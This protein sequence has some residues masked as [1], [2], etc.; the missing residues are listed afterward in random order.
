MARLDDKR[1][2]LKNT[3]RGSDAEISRAMSAVRIFVV[4]ATVAFVGGGFLFVHHHFKQSNP[5]LRSYGDLILVGPPPWL[6]EELKEKIGYAA[7]ADGEDLRLD[8]DAAVTIQNHLRKHLVWLAD[9]KVR[10]NPD[11]IEISGRWRK[12][13]AQIEVNNT[14]FYLDAES[15]VLDYVEVPELPI[16]QIAGVRL[17]GLPTIGEALASPDI[18]AAM[19]ILHRM[20][21][22]DRL[23]TPDAPLLL[24]IKSINIANFRGRLSKSDPHITMKSVGGTDIV[25]GAELDAWSEQLEASDEEKLAKLYAYYRQSRCLDDGV[26]FINLREPRDRIPRPVE[27]LPR[28]ANPLP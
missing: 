28:A 21:K 8:E 7:T 14:L 4:A 11:S 27:P 26:R 16:I 5:V 25:W 19:A 6:N 20:D 24:H 18:A 1:K 10:V 12:P 23:V 22:M 9:P 2:V 17:S 15:V 3:A 13:L